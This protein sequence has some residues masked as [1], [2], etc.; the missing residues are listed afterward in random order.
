[1]HVIIKCMRQFHS[2][3]IREP[4]ALLFGRHSLLRH[5]NLYTYDKSFVL[6]CWYYY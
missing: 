3:N 4:S 2:A 1:M 6:F 5:F